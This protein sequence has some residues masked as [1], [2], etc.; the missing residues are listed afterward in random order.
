M[1]KRVDRSDVQR[2]FVQ[3]LND[4]GRDF[5]GFSQDRSEVGEFFLAGK[6]AVQQQVRDFGVGRFA[7]EVF[8]RIAAIVQ[9][10]V[11]RADGGLTRDESVES[12]G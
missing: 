12:G 8:N 1:A 9:P 2:D 6:F 11:E 3:E 5:G 4:C 7:D 10:F